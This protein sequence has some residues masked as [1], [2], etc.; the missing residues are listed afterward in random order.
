M[1]QDALNRSEGENDEVKCGVGGALVAVGQRMVLD[2][3][4]EQ[5]RGLL[6]ELWVGL[7]VA[8]GRLR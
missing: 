1:R 8:K 4:L 5:D 6:L 7:D 3:M 2:Q